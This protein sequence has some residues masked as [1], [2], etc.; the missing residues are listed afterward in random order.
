MSHNDAISVN[1][2][3]PQDLIE[4]QKIA[5]QKDVEFLQARR[6]EFVTVACPG[7]GGDT[8]QPRFEKY[9][10]SYVTCDTCRT[11]FTNPRPSAA[12]LEKF[13]AGSVN[14]AY[15]NE[16]IFPASEAK[17]REKIFSPRV[18]LVIDLCK[19]YAPDAQS[20]LEVGAGFGTFCE[21]MLSRQAFKKVVAVEPGADLAQTCRNRGIEVIELPVEQVSFSE[22]D[23][24]DVIVNFE[25]IE[26]LFSPK[27][28]IVSCRGMVKTGGLLIITCPNG[29][30]FDVVTIGTVSDTVDH[31]HL[32]YLNPESLGELMRQSGFEVVSARTPGKLDAELVRNKVIE[33]AFSVTDQ[34][35]LKKV[36][37]DDWDTLGQP[38]QEFL[39]ENLLSSNMLLIARAI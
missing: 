29:E 7:C 26:H 12:L 5:I 13:Y 1:D 32:N 2:I 28:F 10:F 38:F 17:R 11:F 37:M 33:G 23:L 18:D 16:V 19:Q 24:F 21:E 3:R 14:Y 25:V 39:Q 9:G 34:P 30:G 6:D 8:Y 35:F 20:L 22:G 31:E 36:L 27:D 15:W 4:G